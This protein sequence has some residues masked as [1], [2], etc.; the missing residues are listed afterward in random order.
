MKRAQ[1]KTANPPVSDAA[2]AQPA[3]QAQLIAARTA[4]AHNAVLWT[5]AARPVVARRRPMGV[6]TTSAAIV[7]L[8][9]QV[10]PL[11]RLEFATVGFLFI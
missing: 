8:G 2:A 6:S 4:G 10:N 7:R 5:A 3:V 9:N 11:Q 1:A